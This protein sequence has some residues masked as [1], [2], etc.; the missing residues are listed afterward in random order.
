MDKIEKHIEYLDSNIE[1]H[2]ENGK[3]SRNFRKKG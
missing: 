3:G 2:S 1:N